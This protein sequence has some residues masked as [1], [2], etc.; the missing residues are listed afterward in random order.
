M[1]SVSQL[2]EAIQT[3]LT[4]RAKDLERQT[5]FVQRSTAQLDGPSFAQTTVLCWMDEPQASYSQLQHVAASLG[6]PVSPQ[7]LEQRFGAA[8]ATLMQRLLEEAVGQVIS[9]EVHVPE[10]LGRFNGVYLQDGSLISLP[11]ELAADWPGWGGNTPEAGQSSLRVQV[12]LELGQGALQGPWL[13]AGRQAEGSGPAV[14]TPLP[15]GCLYNVDSGYFTLAE[16]RRHDQEGHFWLTQAKAHVKLYDQRGQ[17]W[18]LLDF[19]EAQ[20]TDRIDVQVQGGVQERLPMR[21]LAVRLSKEQVQERRRRANKQWEG[22]PKGCRPP[23]KGRTS[24]HGQRQR[25]RKNRRVSP[26]RQRLLG[27]TVLLTNVPAERL[28]LEEALVLARCRWQIELLWKLWKQ[29]GQLDTW[30]SMKPQRVLTELLAKLIGLVITHWETL[31]GCWQAPNRSL[32][33]AKQ[34]V[35]WMAPGLALA[36][37]GEVSMERVLERTLST[38]QRG[39]TLNTRRKRPTTAQLVDSPKLN[40]S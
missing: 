33:K 16:M 10:L 40:S 8:S 29:Y 38:M 27:W 24:T 6:V 3:V 21:L 13:Q 17:C 9:R 15:K 14:Q 7:A 26:A 37:A 28:N 12:R 20:G 36:L 25:W 1:T 18:D 31:L 34:V 23:G 39:C 30:R 35:Q 5:G 32:V 22:K 2:S 4:T 19:L 11:A